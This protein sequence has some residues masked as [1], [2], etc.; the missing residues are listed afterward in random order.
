MGDVGIP[1]HGQAATRTVP[2]PAGRMEG[3]LRDVDHVAFARDNYALTL[4]RI[5]DQALENYPGLGAFGVEVPTVLL[6]QRRKLAVVP[7]DDG[8]H[9][10]VVP[11]ET[12]ATV[13][14]VCGDQV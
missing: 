11:N 12:A 8:S 7:I 10:A 6:I 14:R 1:V 3:K 4:D 5:A 2:P 13:V 9:G